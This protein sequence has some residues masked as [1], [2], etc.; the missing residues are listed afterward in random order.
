[1]E[2]KDLIEAIKKEKGLSNKAL[3]DTLGCDESAIWYVING[4]R[5]G[6]LLYF[7]LIE[8]YPELLDKVIGG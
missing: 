6:R 3:A 8:K 5:S 2:V 1:M 4:K 7:T